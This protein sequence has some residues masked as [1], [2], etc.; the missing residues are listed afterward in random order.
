[1]IS[2]TL[3]AELRLAFSVDTRSIREIFFPVC[4]EQFVLFH[5]VSL[6]FLCS[7][8]TLIKGEQSLVNFKDIVVLILDEILNDD[9][10]LV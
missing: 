7:E 3:N 10:E 6:Q 1:M 2:S 8:Q 4:T 5:P 9:V